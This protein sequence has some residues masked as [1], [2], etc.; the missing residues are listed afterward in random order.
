MSKSTEAICP[1]SGKI[2]HRTHAEAHRHKGGV[3]SRAGH[4]GLEA[5]HCPSCGGY[6]LG[7]RWKRFTTKPA[8]GIESRRT[9]DHESD[10]G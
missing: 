10:A 3:M 9:I 4:R 6:H 8:H 1:A 7:R 5:Y 2:I